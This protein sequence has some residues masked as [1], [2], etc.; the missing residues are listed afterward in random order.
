MSK[1]VTSPLSRLASCLLSVET[2]SRI[3]L[4]SIRAAAFVSC[5]FVASIRHT[6][7]TRFFQVA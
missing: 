1:V 6:R 5:G 3:L 2:G 4:R 7:L